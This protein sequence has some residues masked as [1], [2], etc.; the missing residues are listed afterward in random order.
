[1]IKVVFLRDKR[2]VEVEA[3]NVSD[4]FPKLSIL[5]EQYVVI[6]NGKIVCEDESLSDG[7]TI[8]LFTV[9]SGG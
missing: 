9:A 5:R 3:K 1:M 6:K 7:D 2:T 8:E 4:V